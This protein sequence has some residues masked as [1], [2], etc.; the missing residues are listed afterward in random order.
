MHILYAALMQDNAFDRHWGEPPRAD[1]PSP[2]RRPVRR[3]PRR[4]A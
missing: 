1:K 3:M 4:K 2:R